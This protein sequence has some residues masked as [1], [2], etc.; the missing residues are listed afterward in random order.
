MSIRMHT[1][2]IVNF[3]CFDTVEKISYERPY[4]DYVI[5]KSHT[6]PH[7]HDEKSVMHKYSSH[8][9]AEYTHPSTV[10]VHSV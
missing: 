10:N 8:G 1:M 3:L 9:K 7:S 6:H 4:T 5:K 2:S